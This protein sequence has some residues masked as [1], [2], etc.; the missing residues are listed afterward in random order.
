M[1]TGK[2]AGYYSILRSTFLKSSIYNPVR[3]LEALPHTS[4]KKHLP[5]EEEAL[6]L[7]RAADPETER[8][9]IQVMLQ[10]LGRIDEVRR[11]T[12]ECVNFDKRTAALYTRK[13]KDG[14]F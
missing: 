8:P 9:L 11:L 6:R 3:K 4:E 5:N 10:T 1:S 14:A 12:W 13:R 2:R 7:I